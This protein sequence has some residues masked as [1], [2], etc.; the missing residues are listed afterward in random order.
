MKMSARTLILSRRYL[1]RGS[2]EMFSS[3]CLWYC[4][5]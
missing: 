4:N 3:P 1:W 2:G 5:C